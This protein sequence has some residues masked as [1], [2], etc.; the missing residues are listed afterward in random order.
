[1]KVYFL[2]LTPTFMRYIEDVIFEEETDLRYYCFHFYNDSYLSH[3]FQRLSY[4]T[5]KLLSG[6]SK[7]PNNC[8]HLTIHLDLP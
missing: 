2:I 1:M 5:E 3:V 4:C 6:R 7:I 8:Y